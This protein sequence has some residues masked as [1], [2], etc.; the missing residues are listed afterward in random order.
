MRICSCSESV[1]HFSSYQ[2][3]NLADCISVR[4]EKLT[5][6]FRQ[7]VIIFLTYL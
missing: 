2:V 6:T 1:Q 3:L 4:G 7:N 5:L